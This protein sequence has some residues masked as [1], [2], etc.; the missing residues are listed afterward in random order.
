[1]SL[2]GCVNDANHIKN[3]LITKRGFPATEV[4]TIYDRAMT[5]T[6]ML[7]ALT[8][9]A[10]KTNTVAVA[11]KIPAVFVMYSGHGIRIP[12]STSTSG[13]ND[14]DGDEGLVP[15]DVNTAGVLLDDTLYS[16]FIKKLH[17]STQ[18][19]IMTDCCNSGTNFDLAYEGTL[20]TNTHNS[21][22]ADVIQLS[23]CKD[24]QLAVEMNGAGLLTSKFLQVMANVASIEKVSTFRKALADLSV[25]G[26]PQQPQVSVSKASLMNGV[27]FPWLVRD[28]TVDAVAIAYAVAK[29]KSDYAKAVAK[30]KA[31]AKAKAVAKAKAEALAKAKALTKAKSKVKTLVTTKGLTKS[32]V[33]V[34][35]NAPPSISNVIT[36]LLKR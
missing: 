11:G 1:M 3:F 17:P 20:L 28:V 31:K 18:L 9:V 5:R 14:I 35:V 12:K 30:V 23:A 34:R 26:N 4:Q 7:T 22:T 25:V 16:Q 36:L 13:L 6:N 10:T 21:V 19:F 32:K 29:A 27:M 15:Y 33:V 8:A 24:N 2:T